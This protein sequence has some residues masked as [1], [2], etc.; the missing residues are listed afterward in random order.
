MD[1]ALERPK[2]FFG[3]NA[4]GLDGS[5]RLWVI[6][7]RMRGDSTEIDLF[8]S[9]GSLVTTIALH[10]RVQTVVFRGE[11]VAVLVTRIGGANDGFEGIDL[12]RAVG[13]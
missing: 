2:P 13:R 1:D 6:T 7:N 10:D 8:S 11:R 9:T 5:H 3:P 4:F 12:Y